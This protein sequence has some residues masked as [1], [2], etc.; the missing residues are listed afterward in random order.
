MTG[1]QFGEN[2]CAKKIL[3]C[4]VNVVYE[5]FYIMSKILIFF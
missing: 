2:V 5:I 1:Y 4:Y 3:D